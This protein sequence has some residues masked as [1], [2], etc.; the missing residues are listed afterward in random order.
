M[1]LLIFIIVLSVLIISH[2]FGHFLVAKKVGARVDEFGL[3]F[4]PRIWGFKKGE[5][6]YSIN[7]LPFGGFVQIFGENG[8]G[9]EAVLEPGRNL[10]TKPRRVRA[11]VLVAGVVFNFVLAWLL[12]SLGYATV[13]LPIMVSGVP[14]GTNLDN[15]ALT[16]VQVFPNS[17]AASV[18]LKP[19]D[20]LLRLARGATRLE[21]K[22][23]TDAVTFLGHGELTPVTLDYERGGVVQSL[24]VS[25]VLGLSGTTDRPAIGIGL[26]TVGTLRL[27]V[28]RAWLEGWKTTISLLQDTVFGF[29]HLISSIFH[30]DQTVL[31]S[32]AGPV[33]LF[34]L[35]GEAS[36]LGLDHLIRLT[37]LISINLAVLNLL[38]F[39]A[40][41]G[42]RLLL[43]F[44]E[45]LRGRRLRPQLVQAVNLAGF[46]LLII[47]MVV[48][49]ISDIAKF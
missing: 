6:T 25:P 1:S 26:E 5:T 29:G 4:P 46:V 34:T 38:P 31:Q 13:G 33:G 10:A 41:D 39:P 11:A 20:V 40:L 23:A 49:T 12:I 16:I 42:G 47:F 14:T 19:G 8:E 48:I 32:V 22:Q 7:W 43:L 37:A 9:S 28:S 36:R 21:T 35:V 24:T 2:E 44:I 27:P 18:G 3:G 15:I 45:W 17:P 30:G